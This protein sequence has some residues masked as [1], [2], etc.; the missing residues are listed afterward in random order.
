MG[1]KLVELWGNAQHIHL[2]DL[3]AAAVERRPEPTRDVDLDEQALLKIMALLKSYTGHDFRHYKRGTV[4]RRIERRLQVNGLRDLSAYCDFLRQ[5]AGEA[6]PLLQDMLI[7]VTCFFRDAAAFDI[8]EQ[9]VIP[10]IQ[11]NRLAG[12]QARIWVAGCATG[13]ESYSLSILMREHAQRSFEAW[14]ADA[15]I[16]ATDIDERAIA[17]ARRGVYPSGIAA[18]MSAARLKQFFMP[19]QGQYRVTAEVREQVLFATHNLLRDPPFSRLDLICCRNLLIYLD[20]R[21]QAN[22]LEMFRYALKPGGFL[23]LG[24]SESPNAAGALF[25]AVDTKN[26]IYRVNAGATPRRHAAFISERAKASHPPVAISAPASEPAPAPAAAQEHLMALQSVSPAS[27]LVNAQ[28]EVLHLSPT[29]GQ[30]MSPAGGVPS[31]DLLSNVMPE[32]RLELR[33]ALFRASPGHSVTTQ[34]DCVRPDGRQRPVAIVIHAL[35]EDG[36]NPPRKLVVFSDAES[37]VSGLDTDAQEDA[38][39]AVHRLIIS[40]LEDDNRRLK[41]HLQDTLERSALSTEELKA[42]NEELQAIN[43]ELRSATEELETSKEELQSMNEELGA[44][45]HELKTKVEERGQINDDLHNLISSSEI[46]TVFVDSR[47]CIK[48]F[49]PQASKLFSLIDSDIGRSLLDITNQ[50]Q[51]GELAADAQAVFEHLRV[52]EREITTTDHRSFFARILPYR[53]ANNRIEGAV[54]TFFD[55]T[56]LK[57]AEEQVRAGEE[58]LRVAAATTSDFAIITTDED[59]AIATWNTGAERIFGHRP[60]EI[61]GRS[62]ATIFTAEDRARGVPQAEMR[63]ATDA[64]RAEDEGWRQRKDGT[65]LYCSGVLTK[66]QSSVGKGFAKIARDLTGSKQLELA[67]ENLLMKEQQA[68]SEARRDVEMKDKFLAVMSHELK[69]PLNLIQVSAELLTRLPDTKDVPAAARIGAT[70]QR[71]VR[72]QSKIINDLLDLSRARTGKL[73]LHPAP[74]DLAE[75]IHSLGQ[76]CANDLEQKAIT[77]A[78]VAPDRLS[79]VC[80]RVRVEQLFWNLIGNAIKFTPVGG[81]ISIGLAAEAHFARFSVADTGCGIAA[82]YLPHVFEMFNQATSQLSPNNGGLGIGLALVQELVHAHGGRVEVASPGLSHG[83]TFTVWLPL[84]PVSAIPVAVPEAGPA[85]DLTG[86][87][88]LAV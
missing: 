51:Y 27:V 13:E 69:Q 53:T 21:A 3:E 16:F 79:C 6:T 48:R 12:E 52:R 22:A 88:I 70:I 42:S 47:M 75:L 10:K 66:L 87:R 34:V 40:E 11:T 58:R 86:W 20:Q 17:T 54:L 15:Q 77:L 18:D 44:V 14:H 4:V 74:V 60:D 7:S 67:R 76:A 56:A 84:A 26:R 59:G 37:D 39:G 41:A 8:L 81:R 72:S 78:V 5:Q 80:D 71:A 19:E 57:L 2:P 73:R 35:L 25:S 83:A 82:D 43:E 31:R 63:L 33:A 46:A 9:E 1:A 36:G 68:V 24:S 38:S 32:L 55:V 23:F 49:T 64:G 30:F 28:L 62:I 61:V 85:V 29:A 65:T 45:N 50:L